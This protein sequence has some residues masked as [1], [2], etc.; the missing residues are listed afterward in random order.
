M[1][2]NRIGWRKGR[3][4]NF[5]FIPGEGR[6]SYRSRPCKVGRGEGKPHTRGKRR[7]EKQQGGR[8]KDSRKKKLGY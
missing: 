6:K 8:G 1:K 5:T 2:M 7:A 4:S 3:Q